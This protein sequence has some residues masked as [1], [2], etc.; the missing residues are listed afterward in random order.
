MSINISNIN[1]LFLKPLP[2]LG[3][4]LEITTVIKYVLFVLLSLVEPKQSEMKMNEVGK[5][6]ANISGIYRKIKVANLL[7]YSN[8]LI[9]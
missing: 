9:D 1:I 8:Q 7:K 3:S 4:T 2:P 5:I 6:P